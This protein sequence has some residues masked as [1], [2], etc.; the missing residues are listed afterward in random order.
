[1]AR[2][3]VVRAFVIAMAACGGGQKPAP[4]PGP[5]E[6]PTMDIRQFKHAG[7]DDI[8]PVPASNHRFWQTLNLEVHEAW[9]IPVGSTSGIL[10]I[11]CIRIQPDGTLLEVK[12]EQSSGDAL[13][14][15]AAERAFAQVQAARNAHPIPV[16]TEELHNI[17]SYVCFRMKND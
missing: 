17:R 1:M 7:D 12:R 14:D 2:M 10:A 8:H 13:Y 3:R 5:A 6:P 16:P 11:I 4:A 9:N 15:A